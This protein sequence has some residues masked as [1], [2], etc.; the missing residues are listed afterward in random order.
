MPIEFPRKGASC[1]FLWR[2]RPALGGAAL[3][4]LVQSK[5]LVFQV[6]R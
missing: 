2:A 3:P 4:F 5:F 1:L 6:K